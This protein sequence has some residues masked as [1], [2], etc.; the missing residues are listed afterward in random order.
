MEAQWKRTPQFFFFEWTNW[1]WDLELLNADEEFHMRDGRIELCMVHGARKYSAR[2]NAKLMISSQK[3][4][5]RIWIFGIL[6]KWDKPS[7]SVHLVLL[8]SNSCISEIF[9]RLA[10]WRIRR[11]WECAPLHRSD[12]ETCT[13]CSGKLR[14]ADVI[15]CRQEI[16]IFP[17]IESKL[18]RFSMLIND[19]NEWNHSFL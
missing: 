18:W 5:K 1:W 19:C 15:K 2:Q 11:M 12:G 7:A 4:G 13:Q 14:T 10:V 3:N 9:G 17:G 6:L 16:N 8:Y